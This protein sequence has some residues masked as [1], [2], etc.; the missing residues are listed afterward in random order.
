MNNLILMA[1]LKTVQENLISNWL[2]PA[3]FIVVA[4]VSI[5]LLVKKQMRE[6]VLF[7]A[8]AVVAAL[9]L[10]SGETLFGKEGIFTKIGNN[11]ATSIGQAILPPET[12]I[13]H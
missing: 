13:Y 9:L 2:A 5:T 6:L 12:I 10:F 1:G 11:A 7:A 8:I 3:F 4:A